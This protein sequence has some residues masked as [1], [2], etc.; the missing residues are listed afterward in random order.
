MSNLELAVRH[1]SLIITL[2]QAEEISVKR[3]PQGLVQHDKLAVP[4]SPGQRTLPEQTLAR[5]LDCEY[6]TAP[7]KWYYEVARARAAVGVALLSW[8]RRQVVWF[9]PSAVIDSFNGLRSEKAPSSTS[10]GV[11]RSGSQQAHTVLVKRARSAWGNFK[12]LE[13]VWR[14]RKSHY[15]LFS[16]VGQAAPQDPLVI[17]VDLCGARSSAA[18]TD[19]CFVSAG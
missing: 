19:A 6:C 4:S 3:T 17:I 9:G 8:P 2:A 5:C 18:E 7:Q 15:D 12:H 14:M 10:S 16:E 13:Q 11:P 1:Q